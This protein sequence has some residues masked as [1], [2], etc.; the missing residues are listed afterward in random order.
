MTTFEYTQEEINEI[1]L[2]VDGK[3]PQQANNPKNWIR[4]DRIKK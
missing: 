2:R 3:T 4:Y 1:R